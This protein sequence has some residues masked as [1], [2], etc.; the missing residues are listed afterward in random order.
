MARKP[1]DAG[2]D[3]VLSFRLPRELHD[4]L[5]EAADGRSVS[6]EMRRRL[7]A[8]FNQVDDQ[9]FA[10]L[11][12]AISHAAAGAA[13]LKRRALLPP[14]MMDRNG[15]RRKY[16]VERLGQDISAY[17]VF[18]TATTRLMVALAPEGI[19]AVSKEAELR[20]AD[21]LVGLALG[22]LGERGIAAYANLSDTNRQLTVLGPVAALE[23]VER[24]ASDKGDER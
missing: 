9:W 10:D 17:K 8:S 23:Q 1:K 24:T 16:D 7:D 2:A 19:S 5:V 14:G 18:A 6:E 13:E 3:A 11:L 12:T 21:Q 20:L 22:A 15:K 4:R